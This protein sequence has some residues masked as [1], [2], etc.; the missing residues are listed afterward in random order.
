MDGMLVVETM[1]K[2]RRLHL[3]EG[4]PL[5]A[6]CRDL[7]LSR[8]VVRKVLRLGA[9]E[10]RYERSRQPPRKLAGSADGDRQMVA[11]LAAVLGGVWP[12][13]TSSS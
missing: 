6:I 13:H 7:G 4:R 3:V 10:F 8:K 9:T 2:I 5:K 1:A 11:V 12:L